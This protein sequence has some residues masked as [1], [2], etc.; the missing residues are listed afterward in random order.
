[1]LTWDKPNAVNFKTDTKNFY[2]LYIVELLTLYLKLLTNLNLSDH[3][4]IWFFER[5]FIRKDV[6]L[7]RK[8][9]FLLHCVSVLIVLFSYPGS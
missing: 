6:F 2:T 8:F 5:K 9:L 7:R 3:G 4:M 1:M